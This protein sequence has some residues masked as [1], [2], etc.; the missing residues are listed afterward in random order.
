M[1]NPKVNYTWLQGRHSLK[2]GYEFQHMLTEVQDVNPLYGRDAYAGQFSAGPSAA[3]DNNL[4]N[5]AD[6]MFGAALDVRAEQHP[7]RQA[8]AEHALHLSA[9]RLARQRQAD[10]ERSACATNTRRRGSEKDNIL[11]NFDPATK[12]MVIAQRRVA[13]GSSTL[14][15]D[16]NNFG[17][18]LG[19]AYT[20]DA[21][22]R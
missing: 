3:A 14:K 9:G 4:Y 11:S 7:G 20:L 10:A 12:T 5:L 6:F 22:E 19:F 21:D 16:R 2:S 17:P 1:F 18:R 15:P 8:P 13:R